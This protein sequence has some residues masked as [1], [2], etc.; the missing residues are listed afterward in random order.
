MRQISHVEELQTI[1]AGTSFLRRSITSPSSC[2]L[3]IENAFQKVQQGKGEVEKADRHYVSWLI[4][5][6]K[7]RGRPS[8]VVVKLAHSTSAAWSLQVWIPCADLHTAHQAT[9]WQ[10]P[11]YKIEEDWH[12]R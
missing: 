2:W 1:Y 3:H 7:N 5:I 11:T 10:H 4:K 6:N 8:G 12:R 9:L